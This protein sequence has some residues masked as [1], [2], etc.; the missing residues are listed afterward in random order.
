FYNEAIS[1]TSARLEPLASYFH[2]D[3]R[4]VKFSGTALTGVQAYM[5]TSIPG[6]TGRVVFTDLSRKETFPN[7]RG[8]LAST[9]V[10]QDG[11]QNDYQLIEPV[12]D[13][14]TDSAYFVSLGTNLNQTRLFLGVNGSANVTDF[15][16]G[17][18]FEIM[19]YV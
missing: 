5:G 9:F 16:Q 15:Q 11:K 6:L 1:L 19:P 3:A 4:P 10:R 13:F 17:T 8:A 14:G 7:V 18:V 2:N 12:F